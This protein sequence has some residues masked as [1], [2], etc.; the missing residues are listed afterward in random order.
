MRHARIHQDL[1]GINRS[2]RRFVVSQDY[3]KTQFFL[4]YIHHSDVN[5]KVEWNVIYEHLI[6]IKLE[7]ELRMLS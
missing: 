7:K 6:D 5:L 3:K 1:V 4:V 2:S